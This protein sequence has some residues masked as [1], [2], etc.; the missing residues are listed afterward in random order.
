[1][2]LGA[3]RR[4]TLELNMEAHGVPIVVRAPDD[5]PIETRGIWVVNLTDEVP[6][7]P[8]FSRREVRRII[9]VRRDHVPEVPRGTLIDAPEKADA[10]ILTWLVDSVVLVEADQHRCMVIEQP[11]G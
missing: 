6:V 1:M 2:N 10:E 8:A 3:L 11:A 9:V 5:E 4:L 7:G